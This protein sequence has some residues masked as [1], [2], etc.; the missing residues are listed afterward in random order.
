MLVRGYAAAR[1]DPVVLY[2][3]PGW[4]RH[5]V[6]L[7]MLPVFVM[8]F[9]AYLPGR[10]GSVMTVSSARRSLTSKRCCPLS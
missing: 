2:A 5:L 10:T 9:A 6:M 7:L 1:F 3:P 4:T 8:L